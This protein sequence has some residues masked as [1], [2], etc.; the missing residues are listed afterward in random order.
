ME[1]VL[2]GGAVCIVGS[3]IVA[4]AARTR[5]RNTFRWLL[6]SLFALPALGMLYPLGWHFL[7]GSRGLT[8]NQIEASLHG[9]VGWLALCLLASPLVSGLLLFALLRLRQAGPATV[10][11]S[12]ERKP[13]SPEVLYFKSTQAAFE[14]SCKFSFAQVQKE[15]P[16]IALVENSS[17]SPDA[18]GYQNVMLRVAG[19]DDYFNVLASTA[20][21]Y[22]PPL[23]PGDLVLWLPM[24]LGEWA[25]GVTDKRQAW[26]GLIV[27]VLAPELDV[28]THNY[29]MTTDYIDY[30]RPHSKK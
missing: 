28:R 8:V 23:H 18:N 30:A 24:E 25:F 17:G 2:I 15:H 3:I 6:L 26:L 9:F 14:Y 27:G 12:R 7:G 16:R 10:A 19:S 1:F 11:E 13:A 29:R 4:A 21:P 5:G 20:A 22:V